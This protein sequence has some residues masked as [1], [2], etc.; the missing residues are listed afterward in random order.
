MQD[1]ESGGT[2]RQQYIV[3]PTTEA[4]VP[5]TEVV[6]ALHVDP[7]VEIVEVQGSQESPSLV[8]ASLTPENA[9]QLRDK[10]QGQ[11]I[12][13]ENAPLNPSS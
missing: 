11:I 9:Q 1:I 4:T 2:D 7:Q 3:G 6:D 5:F 12:V 8:V 13:E 10:Y